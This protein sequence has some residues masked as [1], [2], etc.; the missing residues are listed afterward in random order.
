MKTENRDEIQKKRANE[1]PKFEQ[2]IMIV[3]WIGKY[4]LTNLIFCS[5]TRNNFSYKEFLLFM[6]KDI[7][8]YSE[9]NKVEE[10]IIFQQDNAGCHTS[11][12]SKTAISILFDKNTVEC[13]PN[14]PDFSHIENVWAI[15]EEKLSKRNI[16]NVDELRK[17]FWIYG[18][19]FRLLNMKNNAKN[20]MKWLNWLKSIIEQE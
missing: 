6:K 1:I 5:G 13:L 14:S 17:I 18:W 3:D 9:D 8:K 4:G 7:D 15:L 2:T 10:D 16:R 11:Y 19:S 20:W 12:E